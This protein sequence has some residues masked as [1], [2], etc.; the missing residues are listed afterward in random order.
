ME[1]NYEMFISLIL[2]WEFLG[3]VLGCAAV[4]EA[5]K[6]FFANGLIKSERIKD[7]ISRLIHILPESLGAAVCGLTPIFPD[8]VPIAVAVLL[9]AF[10]GSVSS[11]LY[12]IIDANLGGLL[13][14]FFGKKPQ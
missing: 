8:T 5:A 13:N 10:G 9:G 11:K 4:T 6:R 1:K 2:S 12:Q 3:V 7:I 14:K